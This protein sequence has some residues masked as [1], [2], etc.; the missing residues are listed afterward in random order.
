VRLGRSRS[1]PT[2]C[3]LPDEIKKGPAE[4][5]LERT[6]AAFVIDFIPLF[7]AF[8]ATLV[9]I[10]GHTWDERRRGL[11]RLTTTGRAVVALGVVSLAYGTWTIYDKNRQISD[12]ARVKQIAYQQIFEGLDALLLHLAD[13]DVLGM[14]SNDDI[15]KRLRDPSYLEELG[16]EDLV[17]Y[18]GSGTLVDPIAND[19]GFTHPYQLYDSHISLGEQLLNDV[20]VKYA[21]LLQ[22]ETIVRINAVLHDDF[23]RRKYKFSQHQV[24][25]DQGV[26]DWKRTGEYSPWGTVGLYYFNAVYTG[27]SKRSGKYDDYLAFISRINELVVHTN[28]R[29]KKASVLFKNSGPLL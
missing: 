2:L 5:E 15:I 24:L 21:H 16:K 20:L 9:G 7:T 23:F 4:Q 8:V 1:A 18:T 25:F 10:I 6:E 22:P 26:D 13:R 19:P 28:A 12:V 27:K 29:Q 11:H 17:N 14:Q 3:P